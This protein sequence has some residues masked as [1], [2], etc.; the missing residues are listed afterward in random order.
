MTT[1]QCHEPGTPH[2]SCL[3][4]HLPRACQGTTRRG[5]PCRF[6]ARKDTNY[7]INHEPGAHTSEA[8]SRAGAAASQ[9]REDRRQETAELLRAVLSFTD[10]AS[11]QVVLD[12]VTPPRPRRPPPRFDRQNRPPR[13]LHRHPQI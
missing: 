7:C 6:P 4:P 11:I 9:A 1:D 10:C 3:T 8:A 13:L 2:P 5:T 12:T